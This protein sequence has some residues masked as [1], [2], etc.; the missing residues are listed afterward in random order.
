MLK[1]DELKFNLREW[2]NKDFEVIQ[3]H[4]KKIKGIAGG[5]GTSSDKFNRICDNIFNL[6][7][8]CN[9]MGLCHAINKPIDVRALSYLL[10]TNKTFAKK[11]NLSHELINTLLTSQKR[12]SLLSLQ[13]FIRTF[14]VYFDQ[15][16]S[17]TEFE[18][19]IVFIKQQLELRNNLSEKSSLGIW[20]KY[21]Q[22]LFSINGPK[23]IVNIANNN[24]EDLDFYF[25]KFSLNG[26][27]DGHFQQVCRYYYYL[28]VLKEI[29]LGDDHDILKEIIKPDVY[30]A[31]GLQGRLL[32]HEILS[33][34]IDRLESNAISDAWQKVI[35]SIAGDPR[36]PKVNH[37]YQKWWML[38][39]ESRISKV[40]GWLSKFDLNIFLEILEDFG[41]ASRLRDLQ[42]MF[43]ARK[44]FLEGLIQHGLVLNSRLF[45]SRNATKYID[46]KYQKNEIPLFAESYGDSTSMIYLQVAHCHIIEGSHNF[47][48]RI[49]PKYPNLSSLL[50]YSKISYRRS[51]L[52]NE[53]ELAYLKEFGRQS[54]LPIA[55]T[56]TGYLVWQH[57]VIQYLTAQG[58]KLDI[59]KLL[60]END[61]IT[62]KRNHLTN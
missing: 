3:Y 6:V 50:D 18:R 37:N 12:L 24:K 32:G 23:N 57:K 41:N 30:N 56:H 29:T 26:F 51:E 17:Q 61:Y 55:V 62:Y 52:S 35:L 31:P 58:I 46:E 1:V 40:K 28:N 15:L 20:K 33:I 8:D 39:G 59:S 54:V 10:S 44:K 11:V 42:R 13:Q 60:T 48:I 47:Q 9:N 14:F 36:V 27:S 5:A 7:D 22:Y 49:F 16:G 2:N 21:K 4:S 25:N 34:M 45:L 43:P 53:I 19:L 38:L